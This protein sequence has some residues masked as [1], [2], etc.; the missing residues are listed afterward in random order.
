MRSA[1]ESLVHHGKLQ[2]DDDFGA[3]AGG[4]KQYI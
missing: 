3:I 4:L 1:A 2:D